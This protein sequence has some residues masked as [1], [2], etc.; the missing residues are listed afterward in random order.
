MIV[1]ITNGR[2]QMTGNLNELLEKHGDGI[3]LQIKKNN[4]FD[5]LEGILTELLKP[6]FLSLKFEEGEIEIYNVTYSY[7]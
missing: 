6:A 4:R 2:I 5:R 7:Y 1:I 3:L